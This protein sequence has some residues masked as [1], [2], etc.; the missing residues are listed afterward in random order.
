LVPL[1]LQLGVMI[2]TAVVCG[3]VMRRMNQPAVLGE[4]LGGILL[5]PTVFGSLAPVTFS[6][7]FPA[8][9]SLALERQSI[10]HVGML[11]F[12]L[13][14]GLEVKLSHIRQRTRQVALTS[15]L[16]LLVPMGVGIAS[17][18]LFQGLWGSS[19]SGSGWAFG[20]F[21]GTALSIS[22]LPV[23]ARILMDVGLLKRELGIVV[24]TAA[25]LDDV[26]GWTLFAI[27][28]NVLVPA[29]GVAG[30]SGWAPALANL[31]LLAGFVVAVLLAGRW[32]ARPALDWMKTH[33]SWPT[34]FIGVTT[35][36]M[37]GA[38][39]VTE[40]LGMHA[41]FG[42][43]L[44]GIAL[45]QALDPGKAN[46][47]H[48]VMHQFAVSFFAPLYFV[49]IGLRADFARHFDLALV[50]LVVV[51]ACLGKIGGASLGAWLG[52]MRPRHALAVGFGM[53]ARG[54][55]EIIL[56]TVALERGLID[57]RIFVALVVMALVT[58]MLGGPVM[59]RLMRTDDV[60]LPVAA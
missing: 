32:L 18:R 34:A 47:A 9:T 29:S 10:I 21:V 53:N 25:A 45:G 19:P 24:M 22:A 54:A 2:L 26:V 49:S 20:V 30:S 36:A 57:Q 42:A 51:V 28:L 23:I 46:E 43:Y 27:I 60:A 41:V 16:G 50:A 4:L 13:V 56:A 7:L 48:D 12:L 3:Q 58:S 1:F 44:V 17:V 55:M 31:G 37:L 35:V 38:A 59:K 40:S 8:D 39:S 52:G 11:F 14:A 33:L 6:R 15:L 5:G